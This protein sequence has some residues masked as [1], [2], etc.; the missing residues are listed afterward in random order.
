MH[1]CKWPCHFYTDSAKENWKKQKGT[2]NMGGLTLQIYITVS[3]QVICDSCSCITECKVIVQSEGAMP[4]FKC[5]FHVKHKNM[6][7]LRYTTTWIT[8]KTPKTLKP[9]SSQHW[10]FFATFCF[11]T[12]YKE[13][14]NHMIYFHAPV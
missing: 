2:F 9:G 7:L 13:V 5:T 8:K 11:Y 6:K 4:L 1:R 10:R 14:K 12:L 3:R